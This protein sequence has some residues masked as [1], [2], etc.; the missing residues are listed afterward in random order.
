M[1]SPVALAIVNVPVVEDVVPPSTKLPP[2]MLG[3]FMLLLAALLPTICR[4]ELFIIRALGFR[5]K[6][7]LP[8]P[9]I[10]TLPDPVVVMLPVKAS[11]ELEPTLSPV[12]PTLKVQGLL[13]ERV[14]VFAVAS[15]PPLPVIGLLAAPTPLFALIVKDP[16]ERVSPPVKVLGPEKVTGACT[17]TAPRRLSPVLASAIVPAKEE[18]EIELIVSVSVPVPLEGPKIKV[19]L[20]DPKVPIVMLLPAV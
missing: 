1:K 7:P 15:V 19:P 10:T 6:V 16:E 8:E 5:F 14:V 17:M 20:P 3:V 11:V 2:A 4:L 18:E 12:V 9:E 13:R